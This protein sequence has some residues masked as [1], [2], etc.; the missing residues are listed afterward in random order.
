MPRGRRKTVEA[1]KA[2]WEAL[3]RQIEVRERGEKLTQL[4]NS[5]EFKVVS[6][7]IARLGLTGEEITELFQRPKEVGKRKK[8]TRR[9]GVKLKPKYRNPENP[10]QVWTGRGNRPRWV[11]AALQGGLTIE[12]LRIKEE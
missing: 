3:K 2:E 1:M 6:K 9:K 8:V 5:K 12:D 11:V 4:S 10:E 7:E